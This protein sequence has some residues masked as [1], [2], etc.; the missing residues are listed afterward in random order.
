MSFIDLHC[1]TLQIYAY[2]KGPS[3]DLYQ[4]TSSVDFCRMKQVGM[5]AQFF[6]MFMPVP[7]HCSYLK[8]PDIY[9][10]GELWDEG[11]LTELYRG[12]KLSVEAHADLVT[13][14]R[15]WAEYEEAK[16]A[17]KMAAFLTVEDGRAVD[18]KMENLRALHRAGVS[19]ITLTWNFKNCFGSPN[20]RDPQIM[21]E[22]LTEFG[23]EAVE[24]MNALG[25]LVDVSHLSD[26]GFYDVAAIS[27]KPF[28]ASHSNARALSPHPRNMTDDMIR[29][30]ADT[31][32]V[33]GLNFCPQFLLADAEGDD[34][35][36]E[37][38]VRHL[39]HI[40]NV[41]G[42]AVMALGG[43]LDGIG[44]NLEIDSVEKTAKLFEVLE[45]HGFTADE[46]EGLAH[47][48]VERVLTES[49]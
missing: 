17:G 35:R 31:G 8:N 10:D 28:V 11:F 44:G 24:E 48:N 38:M 45:K 2:E 22:G 23:K 32:G 27:K 21:A 6:A 49:L 16:K 43:D 47:K 34:S 1:D 7:G 13:H 5:K 3:C 39:I 36:I 29:R 30:L 25:M 4:N 12:F 15:N 37:D 26:G 41:G 9:R 18:G 42:S 33:M 46:L 40:R 14:T 20:S 19:L